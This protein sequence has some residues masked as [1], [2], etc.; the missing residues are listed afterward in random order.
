[1]MSSKL[2]GHNMNNSGATNPLN[3]ME[4]S[5][6]TTQP[7]VSAFVEYY[8]LC[9]K[10]LNEI[11]SPHFY[12]K[13]SNSLQTLLTSVLHGDKF[14]QFLEATQMFTK[15]ASDIISTETVCLNFL[16]ILFYMKLYFLFGNQFFT[17]N[18]LFLDL[19]QIYQTGHKN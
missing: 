4:R 13:F 16:S 8:I 15:V 2:G 12:M 11:D 1:M 3:P 7:G 10:F 9:L 19:F 18:Q 5:P 14:N 6:K 17:L